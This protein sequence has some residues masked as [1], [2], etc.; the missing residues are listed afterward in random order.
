MEEYHNYQAIPVTK[1]QLKQYPHLL[2]GDLAAAAG[3][4]N[5]NVLNGINAANLIGGGQQLPVKLSPAA[6]NVLAN[7]LANQLAAVNSNNLGIATAT[8]IQSIIKAQ[9]Q[10]EKQRNL[11]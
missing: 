1:N 9:Q 10:Q 6:A 5:Y 7:H 2:R 4:V 11:V 3:G 8:S